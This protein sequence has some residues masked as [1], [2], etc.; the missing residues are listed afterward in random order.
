MKT[1]LARASLCAAAAAMALAAGRAL[2]HF[3]EYRVSVKGTDRWSDAR[4]LGPTLADVRAR[5]QRLG[6]RFR[7]RIRGQG[8][9][10]APLGLPAAMDEVKARLTR[11]A[12]GDMVL[13]EG[14]TGL[15]RIRKVLRNAKIMPTPGT[16]RIDR[17]HHF[18]WERFPDLES[19]GICNCR[20]ISGSSTWS[21]HAWCNAEDLHRVAGGSV[22]KGLD[23]VYRWLQAN[24]RRFH[25]AHILWQVPDHY[26]HIHVDMAP[27]ESGTPPCAR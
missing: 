25:I 24:Q 13:V 3:P 11:A 4:A 20:R 19:W 26:D 14:R 23:P 5:A 18:L 17:L 1:T 7:V 21:Q 15:V 27:N 16:P 9:W 12:V 22:K 2:A 8:T 10:T 6:G